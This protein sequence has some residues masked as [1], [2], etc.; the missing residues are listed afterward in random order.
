MTNC[1]YCLGEHD[2]RVACPEMSK[3][4]VTIGYIAFTKPCPWC[5]ER[6]RDDDYSEHPRHCV[7]YQEYLRQII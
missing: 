5:Q 2:D 4:S 7:F 6:V 3:A 1:K